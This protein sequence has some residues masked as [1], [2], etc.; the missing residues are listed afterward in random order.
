MTVE[1]G[2]A[3]RSAIEVPLTVIRNGLTAAD[4][5]A[6]V[7]ASLRFAATQ[8]RRRFTV[9]AT[10]DAIDDDGES[11]TIRI[12]DVPA[13]YV[14][15]SVPEAT[16][17]LADNDAPLAM[18]GA[19]STPPNTGYAFDVGDFGFVGAD[20]DVLAGVTIVTLPNT[21]TLTL[22]GTAMTAQD[23]RRTVTRADLLAGRLVYRPPE[24]GTGAGLATF[25]FRVNDGTGLSDATY[26]MTVDVVATT[27][28]EVNF[29]APGYT[30]TEGGTAAT[31]AVTLSRAPAAEAVIPLALAGR[32]WGATAADHSAIPASVTFGASDTSA[33]FTVSATDDSANDDGESVTVALGTVPAGFVAGRSARTTVSLADDE[34]V[35]VSNAGQTPAARSNTSLEDKRHWV[36][37]TTGPHPGGYVLDSI[38]ATLTNTGEALSIPSGNLVVAQTLIQD[39]EGIIEL[40]DPSSLDANATKTYTF[41]APAGATLRPSTL[42]IMALTSLGTEQELKDVYWRHTDSTAEDAAE[43]GWSIDD[44]SVLPAGLPPLMLRVNGHRGAP[45]DPAAIEVAFGAPEYTAAEGA[46]AVAVAVVLGRAPRTAAVVPLTLSRNGGA[47]ASDHSPIPASVTFA[48]GQTEVSFTVTAT[49]DGEDDPG[50]SITLE[51]GALPAGYETWPGASTRVSLVDDDSARALVSNLEVF[52]RSFEKNSIRWA[53]PRLSAQDFHTGAHPYGFELA[54][55]DLV[56]GDIQVEFDPVPPRVW[57][58]SGSPL[59]SGDDVV[60]LAGPAALPSDAAG[61]L[62]RGVYRYTAPG[63]TYLDPNARY[64]LVMEGL[65]DFSVRSAGWGFT[66]DLDEDPGGAPGWRIGDRA[67]VADTETMTISAPDGRIQVFAVLGTPLDEPFNRPATGEPGITGTI[68]QGATLTAQVP[69]TIED[70]NG[71]TS[72]QWEYQWIRARGG[73]AADIEGATESTYVL[74]PDDVL[75]TVRLAVSFTDDDGF[76]ERRTSAPTPYLPPVAGI[77]RVPHDWALIPPNSNIGAGGRFRLLFVTAHPDV[78]AADRE[79]FDLIDATATD[80]AVYNRFVHGAALE[81][82]AAIRGYAGHFRALAS[83]AAANARDNTATTASD[84]DTAVYWLGGQGAVQSTIAGFYGA[85]DVRWAVRAG[86]TDEDGET[87]SMSL[88]DFVWTGTDTSGAT[89]A[90]HALGTARPAHAEPAQQFGQVNNRLYERDN[91]VELPLYALSGVF[92]VG[93]APGGSGN[94]AHGALTRNAPMRIGGREVAQRRAARAAARRAATQRRPPRACRGPPASATCRRSPSRRPRARLRR[95]KTATWC[96]WSTGWRTSAA[97]RSQ[98]PP[99]ARSRTRCGCPGGRRTSAGWTWRCGRRWSRWIRGRRSCRSC[100][101]GRRTSGPCGW[102]STSRSPGASPPVRR[103]ESCTR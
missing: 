67:S 53:L 34:G 43:P 13:P 1:L 63:G 8:T 73:T 9:T 93:A 55:V 33:T 42:Y 23:L 97:P 5:Y 60:E 71:L 7:P 41:A 31:V 88:N 68:S 99:A 76:A 66:Y 62:V 30:A 95:P 16:V 83:T 49:D 47:A 94:R 72:P 48:A 26:T 91:T 54:A 19:V 100:T 74:G 15:G 51:F 56:L 52:E 3:P 12:G 25:T 27:D 4:D 79:P 78:T 39:S 98:P 35:L 85:G 77:A 57:L 28:I 24:D 11:I 101:C 61:K 87:A 70:G 102:A 21:G 96:S 2:A 32:N 65:G 84:T 18:D 17:A 40:T 45:R 6:G 90:D 38:E 69:G 103:C 58:A 81:G 14:R 86:Q 36:G 46:G 37:Y 80:I 92:E 20:G 29:G 44:Q 22:G 89:S 50:E 82:H 64:W 59:D 10:D 75:H